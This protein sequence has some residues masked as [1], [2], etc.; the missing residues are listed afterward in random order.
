MNTDFPYLDKTR[1]YKYPICRKGV[2]HGREQW[3]EQ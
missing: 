2:N 3:N 1:D